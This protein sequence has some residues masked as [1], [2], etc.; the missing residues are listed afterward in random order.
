MGLFLLADFIIQFGMKESIALAIMHVAG[1]FVIPVTLI[2]ALRFRSANFEQKKL[3]YLTFLCCFIELFSLTAIKLFNGNNLPLLHVFTV[4]EFGLIVSMF[5]RSLN[6]YLSKIGI[7]LLIGLF[8]I[9]SLLNSVF[10]ESIF[11]FNAFAR[12]VEALIIILLSL[13]Y[14]YS[15]LR[16]MTEKD[17]VSSPMFWISSGVLLYF[18]ASLFIFIYS[19][20]LFGETK[21]SF[22]IWGL[23]AIMSIIL[24]IFYT[25]ALWV[26]PKQ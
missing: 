25:I 19:N 18:S 6:V 11:T 20:I 17:L 4:L 9:F 13:L 23:H 8:T 2:A 5:K 24:Y 10:Y 15:T 1:Y 14:F 21:N 7:Y 22:T 26:K 3:C 12:A 16:N